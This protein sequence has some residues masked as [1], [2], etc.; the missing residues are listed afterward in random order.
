[1]YLIERKH[2]QG[3]Q[4]AEGKPLTEQGAWWGAWSQDAGIMTWAEDTC[5][6]NWATQV[7][8]VLFIYM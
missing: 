7:P 4:Q 6:I 1:M 2:K 3:E 5:L 8:Q